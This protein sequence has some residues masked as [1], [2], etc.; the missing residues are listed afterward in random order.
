[1]HHR[2]EYLALLSF[3]LLILALPLRLAQRLGALLGAAFSRILPVRRRVALENLRFAFPEMK[4]QERE[5]IAAGAFRNYGITMVELLWFP[6]LTPERIAMLIQPIHLER[7]SDAA[8]RGHGVILLSGHLGNW[9][10]GA[11]G[12][13][14]LSRIPFTIIVQTQ[15][16]RLVDRLINRHRCMFGNKVVPMGPSVRE[17]IRTLQQGGVVGI[18]PDQSG[19]EEGVFV[20]FFGRSVA[21]HQGPAAFALRVGAPLI[22]GIT[23]R[24][25]DGT[26]TVKLEEVSMSDLTEATEE[27]IKELTQRHTS[28]L[29]LHIRRRPDHWL[30]MHRRWKH[31]AP[32]PQSGLRGAEVRV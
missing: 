13:G 23:E 32:E 14:F 9:E 4:E 27:N 20:E 7:L 15:N 12:M 5:R 31:L 30:W 25:V 24:Q 1:M 22:L 17:I 6:R 2:L 8:A 21:T 3:R 18:A 26:Y 16:N 19:P 28:L 10:L 29:E 11:L